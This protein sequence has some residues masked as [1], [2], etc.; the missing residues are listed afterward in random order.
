MSTENQ[1]NNPTSAIPAEI[2]LAGGKQVAIQTTKG[3]RE[4]VLV[5]LATL[6]QVPKLLA[7]LDK[8]AELLEFLCAKPEGWADSLT[9]ECAALLLE[10]GLE[11]NRPTIAGFIARQSHL[12]KF[13]V[14]AL[15]PLVE[16]MREMGS[17]GSSLTQPSPSTSP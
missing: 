17:L 6:R 10:E 15:A 9:M 1:N 8:E 7:L 16:R 14:G 4:L 13:S 2:L 3:E 11:L 5:R 12:A